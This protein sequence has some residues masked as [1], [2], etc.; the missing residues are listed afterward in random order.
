M[1]QV[2]RILCYQGDDNWVDDLILNRCVKGNLTV[3]EGSITET[4]IND[5][6]VTIS[7]MPNLCPICKGP[8]D[9]AGRCLD[10]IT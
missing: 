1:K 2:I 5:L 6:P 10:L 7:L 3:H 8:L 9:E 4:I